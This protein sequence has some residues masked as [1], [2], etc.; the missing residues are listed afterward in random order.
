MTCSLWCCALSARA[1]ARARQPEKKYVGRRKRRIQTNC[2]CCFL[3]PPALLGPP[4]LR[5]S[6]FLSLSLL[7]SGICL[8]MRSRASRPPWRAYQRHTHTHTHASRTHRARTH[9][10]KRKL[11]RSA[12]FNSITLVLCPALV[13]NAARIFSGAHGWSAVWLA[14]GGIFFGG[15]SE[16]QPPPLERECCYPCSRY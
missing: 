4:I 5:S 15:R 16:T 1:R 13:G 11:F 10:N 8:L 12:C 2:C 6:F 7:L 9:K 3:C 14:A